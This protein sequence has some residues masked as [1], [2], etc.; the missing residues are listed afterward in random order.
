VELRSVGLEIIGQGFICRDTDRCIVAFLQIHTN[1]L[2]LPIRMFKANFSNGFFRG[3]GGGGGGGQR[4]WVTLRRKR[5][6][7]DFE[8]AISQFGQW[9]M[10]NRQ[11]PGVIRRNV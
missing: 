3:G 10:F 1:L 8:G 4:L 7:H 11:P 9:R 6:R 5:R 2:H